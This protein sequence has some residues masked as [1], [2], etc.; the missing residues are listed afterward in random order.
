MPCHYINGPLLPGSWVN[1]KSIWPESGWRSQK[2]VS[3]VGIRTQSLIT[4]CF[5]HSP[6]THKSHR[7]RGR[8]MQKAKTL[9]RRCI[10]AMCLCNSG[11]NHPSIF[12]LRAT[13]CASFHNSGR[14]F[15]RHCSSRMVLVSNTLVEFDIRAQL[16]LRSS[17]SLFYFSRVARIVSIGELLLFELFN[18]TIATHLALEPFGSTIIAISCITFASKTWKIYLN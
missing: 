16:C 9:S 13:V 8:T 6:P 5:N 2:D 12:T 10:C 4:L 7:H 14:A 15:V 17:R 11:L 3:A 18:N 1:V